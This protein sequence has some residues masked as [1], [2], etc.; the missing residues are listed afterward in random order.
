MKGVRQETDSIT[1]NFNNSNGTKSGL[2]RKLKIFIASILPGLFLI[3]FNIG[4]GSVTAMSKAGADYGMTLLWTVGISCIIT[5]FLITIFGKFTI[6]T[7]ETALEAFKKQ[8]HPVFAIFFIFAMTVSV[9]GSVIGVMGIIA[10]I[11]HE[12][13]LV[14]LP[15]GIKSVYFAAFFILLVYLF[16]L[17][18]DYDFFQKVLAVIVAIMGLC[19][20]FNFF[21][22]MPSAHSILHGLIPIIP[23]QVGNK[24][25][26]L[27]VTSMVG[28]TVS[29]AIFIVR[30]TLV[31]EA[32]WT[33][34]DLKIQNRDAIISAGLM[35]LISVAIMAAA[36]GTLYAHGV[37][38]TKA[39]QMITLLKP[40]AGSWATLI[41]GVGI[42]AAG[43]SSQFPNVLLLPILLD[44]YGEKKLDMKS[45][46]IRI[47]VLVISL[48]GLI[49]PLTHAPPVLVL[50]MS[51]AF[52]AILL[53]FTVCCI[54]YLGNKKALM[55]SYTF[56]LG[57]NAFLGLILAF[58]LF[59]GWSALKG[60]FAV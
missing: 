58:S 47:I 41:F 23:E 35:F 13:S 6:V 50:I 53:P 48:M 3:G 9:S 34:K 10:A 46:T 36:A 37:N 16:F 38:M 30:T 33:F 2:Y 51:Q 60:I 40:L 22:L 28:T 57:T 27:V 15:S 29:S 17:K 52:G 1:E 11:C 42:I 12:V 31:E 4:T 18:G 24:M 26:L 55:K 25:P 14:Y 19:F 32:N 49:V 39:S 5:Y 21:Y 44:Q 54:L 7:G 59:M 45:P 43:V 56:S 8:I 20:F